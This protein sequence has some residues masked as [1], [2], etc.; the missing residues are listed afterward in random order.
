MAVGGG[1]TE[2]DSRNGIQRNGTLAKRDASLAGR[3]I[4][5]V[6]RHGQGNVKAVG[7]QTQRE[8]FEITFLVRLRETMW[9]TL[10]VTR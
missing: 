6:D 7:R 2:G 10:R 8:P 5:R 1:L 3:E 4:R 9:E